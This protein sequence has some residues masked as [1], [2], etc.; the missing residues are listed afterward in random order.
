MTFF[1]R[2]DANRSTVFCVGTDTGFERLLQD[3]LDQTWSEM[4][5]ESPWSLQVPLVEAIIAFQDRGVWTMRDVVR[6]VEKV[7]PESCC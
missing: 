6:G 1:T 3:T 4:P 2:W 5:S 7:C